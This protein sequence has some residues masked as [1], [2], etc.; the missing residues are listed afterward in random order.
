MAL[1]LYHDNQTPSPI[2]LDGRVFPN[3]Q[4]ETMF[5]ND[6]ESLV[7][8]LI[9]FPGAVCWCSRN[10]TVDYAYS[11][12]STQWDTLFEHAIALATNGFTVSRA[13][14]I[15][16]ELRWKAVTKI[17]RASD[18]SFPTVTRFSG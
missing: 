1:L 12:W 9:W 5:L 18:Y 10:A 6:E 14:E 3:A 11:L 8:G 15:A 2:S 7:V 16:Q 4:A 17:H 13:F